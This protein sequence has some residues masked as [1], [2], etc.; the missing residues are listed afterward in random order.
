MAIGWRQDV[1]GKG[2]IE[3]VCRDDGLE[4][5]ARL[6]YW[7]LAFIIS[8]FV[9]ECCFCASQKSDISCCYLTAK[10]SD[11]IIST[12]ECISTFIMYISSRY[13]SCS[14][15]FASTLFEQPCMSVSGSFCICNDIDVL[16]LTIWTS[17]KNLIAKPASESSL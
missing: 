12:A 9:N 4:L 14:G 3:W 13:Y 11:N 8:R 2:S 16:F 17:V 7:Y 10:G 15:L 6:W 5:I 1:G